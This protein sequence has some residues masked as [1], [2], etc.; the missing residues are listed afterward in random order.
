MKKSK[1][2]GDWTIGEWRNINNGEQKTINPAVKS[3]PAPVLV[4]NSKGVVKVDPTHMANLKSGVYI[5]SKNEGLVKVDDNE[6]K[7][8]TSNKPNIVKVKPN[9]TQPAAQ[10]RVVHKTDTQQSGI[11]RMS[12]GMNANTSGT[13]NITPR[14]TIT[15][16]T[17][18]I[19]TPQKR[20]INQTPQR[21][22]QK[23]PQQIIGKSPISPGIRSRVG[24]ATPKTSA[25][26]TPN[27]IH[28][29]FH[30]Q[31]ES[32]EDEVQDP[33][34]IDLPAPGPDSPPRPLTLCPLTGKVLG[35]AEGEQ[36]PDP[37]QPVEAPPQQEE[38][39]QPQLVQ[40][41]QPQVMEVAQ[42]DESNNTSEQATTLA[43]LVNSEEI[44]KMETTTV[45]ISA[46]TGSTEATDMILSDASELASDA[47]LMI[48]GEDGTIYQ[49]AGQDE[50]GQTLLVA[51]GADGEQQCVYLAA[52]G[53][54][55]ESMLALDPE[56]AAA[57][58][59]DSVAQLVQDDQPVSADQQLMINTEGDDSQVVA[60]VV[61]AELPS[62]GKFIKY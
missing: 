56:T 54:D 7:S 59:E 18:G 19:S 9:A 3:S 30:T 58:T 26:T 45:Q 38:Q 33:F 12:T 49:V 36:L 6:S 21:I 29:E 42:Q 24:E 57:M 31:E 37:N 53:E 35:H 8:N 61:K 60:Q 10:V 52:G 34:P 5:M 62:P 50:N 20:V 11:V 14:T 2:D 13:K 44:N 43:S 15:Q 39:Q 48:T 28:M 55:G 23:K 27:S 40:I 17:P 1:R 25:V 22:L 4:A 32:S 47:P 41:Q 46:E 16:A 51:Q